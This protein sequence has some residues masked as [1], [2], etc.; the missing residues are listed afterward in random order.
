[1]HGLSFVFF[2]GKVFAVVSKMKL[3]VGPRRGYGV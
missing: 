3:R 1:M 2:D